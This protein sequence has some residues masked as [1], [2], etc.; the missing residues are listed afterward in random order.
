MKK[1]IT[2]FAFGIFILLIL[3]FSK[4][5]NTPLYFEVPKGWPKPIYDFTKNPLSEEVF[6]LGRH[7]FY[8]PILS[9]NNTISCSSCHLQQTGF[10]HVDHQLSHGIEGK[11][12]TR[13]AMVLINLNF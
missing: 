3:A 4:S 8:D 12:G 5:Y 6:Q 13:N 10:T 1:T 7:L 2:F 11:I 9:R